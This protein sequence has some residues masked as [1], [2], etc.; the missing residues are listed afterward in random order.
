MQSYVSATFRSLDCN[1]G[2][3]VVD[4]YGVQVRV[5]N[6]CLIVSDG[7]G[8]FRRERSFSKAL[9]GIKRLVVISHEGAITLEALRWLNDAGIAFLQIDRD[10]EVIAASAN[11][12]LNDPRLR[13]ALALSP[14][15]T[16]GLEIARCVLTAKLAGQEM[17][18]A[19]SIFPENVRAELTAARKV[20]ENAA[21]L[22]EILVAES[23][24]AAAYWGAWKDVS[25]RFA[26]KDEKSIPEHWHIF[27]QR[28]S[29]ITNSP[30]SAANPANAMLNYLYALLETE[31]RF[32]CL[33]C[34]LDP[35]LGVFHADQK[36]RDSL[37]L[38]LM[39]ATR[40]QIDAHLLNLLEARTFSVK[41]FVETRRGVCRVLAPLTHTLAETTTRWAQ[42]VAPVVEHVAS[43]L[44][45]DIRTRVDL[46]T[47]LT[48]SRRSSGRD[49]LRR[50]P[51][52]PAAP[53]ETPMATC[54]ACGGPLPSSDRQFCDD[55]LPEERRRLNAKFLA[56]SAAGLAKMHAEGRN[57]MHSEE[58][59]RRLGESNARRGREAAEW[60]RVH[61]KPDPEVF[62]REILPLLQKVTLPQMRAA[63][64][65][66]TTMCARIRRGY[67]PHPRHWEA[68]RVLGP[69]DAGS[70]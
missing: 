49:H 6:R 4:G 69:L 10:G 24:G 29:P 2:V 21:S 66:S 59:R 64:G 36:S 3:C 1:G 46:P 67:V 23:S 32:A 12:R 20:A 58:G 19:R 18:L 44:A 16:T 42:A 11:Y 33:A 14:T 63:T 28:S 22:Q 34:G 48:Q 31:T 50:K 30:R 35:G 8:R 9:V 65:L 60:D 55:C 13:R 51:R 56:A 53:Q 38:D 41:D 45:D 27:G 5:R 15:N 26:R 40:P 54:A 37:V 25:L 70:Q 17:N 62:T 61:D 7:I 43:L 68:L 57:P 52:R 39:E 47:P